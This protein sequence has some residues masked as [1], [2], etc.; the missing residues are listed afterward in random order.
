MTCV[1]I[2][3]IIEKTETKLVNAVM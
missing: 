3:R 2:I 1:L